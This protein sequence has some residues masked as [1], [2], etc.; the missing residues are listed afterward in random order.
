MELIAISRGSVHRKD[1]KNCFE[2]RV[3]SLSR[4]RGGEALWPEHNR[5]KWWVDS[6]HMTP[7]PGE[8]HYRVV[9]TGEYEADLKVEKEGYNEDQDCEFHNVLWVQQGRDGI[10][11]RAGCG[12]ILA[13]WRKTIHSALELLWASNDGPL[14]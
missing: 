6:S 5:E 3:F 11:Y 4:Y 7:A 2:E 1:L 14:S 13:K 8:C 10:K 12:R 9:A